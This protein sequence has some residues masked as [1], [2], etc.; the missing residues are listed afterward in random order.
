MRVSENGGNTTIKDTNMAGDEGD[1]IGRD[2]QVRAVGLSELEN[3]CKKRADGK[4]NYEDGRPTVNC[5]REK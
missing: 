2:K 5:L 1:P 3:L 4:M